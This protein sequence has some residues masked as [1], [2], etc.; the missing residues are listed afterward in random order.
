MHIAILGHGSLADSLARAAERAGHVV[1]RARPNG[2]ADRKV[3]SASLVVVA[4]APEIDASDPTLRGALADGAVVVDAVSPSV[5]PR[6]MEDKTAPAAKQCVVRAFASVPADRLASA[7]D[8][9]R[10]AGG[11]ASLAVPLVGDNRN[12]K[13]VVERFIRDIGLEPFDVGPLGTANVIEPG[14]PLWG[15]AYTPTEMLEAVGDLSGDG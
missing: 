3:T 7:I 11:A 8:Q 14:G 1:A 10:S 5:L 6:L 12:A 13:V 2:K 4:D 9:G 15:K